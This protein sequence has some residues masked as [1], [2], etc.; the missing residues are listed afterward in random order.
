[1]SHIFV[2]RQSVLPPL[3]CIPTGLQG[4]IRATE[5]YYIQLPQKVRQQKNPS[6]L[7]QEN[8]LGI[9]IFGCTTGC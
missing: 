5:I 9:H 4:E 1:M 2:M 3:L 8:T 6:H 7:S